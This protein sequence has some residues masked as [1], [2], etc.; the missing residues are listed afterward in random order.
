[1]RIIMCITWKAALC[2]AGEGESAIGVLQRFVIITTITTIAG[3]LATTSD[4]KMRAAAPEQQEAE[5]A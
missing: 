2:M 1:M 4:S 3:K 5:G